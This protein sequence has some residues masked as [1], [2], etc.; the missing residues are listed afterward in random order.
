MEETQHI[1]F[2]CDGDTIRVEAFGFKG[3]ACEAATGAIISRL[4]SMG[5]EVEE[6]KIQIDYKP[7]YYAEPQAAKGQEATK[8]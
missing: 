2:T 5:I 6:D 8:W 7:E 3:K 4:R 1:R